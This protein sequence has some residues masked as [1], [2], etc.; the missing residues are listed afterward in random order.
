TATSVRDGRGVVRLMDFGIA[1]D[2]AAGTAAGLT[3]TGLIVGTPEYMSPEQ[4][5]GAR[6]D[7]RADLYAFGIVVYELF[8]GRVPFRA[9]TP[10]AVI[11]QHITEPPPLEGPDA[12]D[13][14][15][16]LRPLLARALAKRPNARVAPAG[17]MG[18]ALRAAALPDQPTL[19]ERTAVLPRPAS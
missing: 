15:G 3:A 7:A 4:A 17:E 10:M 16:A 18:D 5:M 14:P 1:K 13:L 9:D 12:A 19:L 11:L 2:G 6:V 8:T